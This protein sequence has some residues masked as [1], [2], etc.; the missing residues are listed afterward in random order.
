MTGHL[1]IYRKSGR[2]IQSH[3][4]GAIK[5]P[6][7]EST[8]FGFQQV[9]SDNIYFFNNTKAESIANS[10]HTLLNVKLFSNN[11]FDIQKSK[12]VKRKEKITIIDS[13][14]ATKEQWKDFQEKVDVN[15]DK[16][17]ISE[18]IKSYQ[19]SEENW[20]NKTQSNNG[21][22]TIKEDKLEEIC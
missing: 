5:P 9:S 10:D 1:L 13:K 8:I 2:K 20:D 4:L 18:L 7:V 3:I 19:Q 22:Q 17:N 16:T 6:P 14:S 11:I 12:V 15:L 21:T